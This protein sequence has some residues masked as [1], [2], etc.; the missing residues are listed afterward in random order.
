MRL[1]A[2]RTVP[3]G[4][5]GCRCTN[6]PELIVLDLAMPVLDGWR[7]LAARASDRR[8]ARVP[9]VIV[10]VSVGNDERGALA[11]AAAV[12]TKPFRIEALLDVVEEFGIFNR[13]Q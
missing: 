2:R 3:K 8:L 9:V 6:L 12:L 5:S 13:P 7:F 10:S 1:N 4:W 11:G